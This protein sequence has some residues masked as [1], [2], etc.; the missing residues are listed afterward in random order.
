M[1]ESKFIGLDKCGEEAE[2]MWQ[3]LEDILRYQKP[4]SAIY[5]Y[6]D[7]QSAIRWV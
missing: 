5:I 6:Y 3:F 7:S 4:M 2:E 1:I